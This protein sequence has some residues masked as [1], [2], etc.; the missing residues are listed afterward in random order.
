M[1]YKGAITEPHM[2]NMCRVLIDLYN[3]GPATNLQLAERIPELNFDQCQNATRQLA[4]KRKAK[5]SGGSENTGYIFEHCEKL[6][7]LPRVKK[8]KTHSP[9]ARLL[10][11]KPSDKGG[12]TPF[13]R[14]GALVQTN[15]KIDFLQGLLS[16]GKLGPDQ[17][18][19]VIGIIADYEGLKKV[20]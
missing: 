11:R 14:G 4:I 5:R 7:V 6:D 19:L 2:T 13:M 12:I 18:D 10:N 3:N 17:K 8:A 16:N 15:R 9:V 1:E 20:G